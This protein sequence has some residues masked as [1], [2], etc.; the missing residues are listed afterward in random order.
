M[1]LETKPPKKR[2]IRVSPFQPPPLRDCA[3]VFGILILFLTWYSGIANRAAHI[4]LCFD[5]CKDLGPN[6][7]TCCG[8]EHP[9]IIDGNSVKLGTKY[10]NEEE[11]TKLKA[12]NTEI[13]LKE[14]TWEIFEKLD[15]QTRQC[16]FTQGTTY[17]EYMKNKGFKWTGQ[18]K[19]GQP[20]GTG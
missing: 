10:F 14:T 5:T 6:A 3:M 9:I 7:C 2:V 16:E 4:N 17:V 8:T 19:N 15:K 18:I 1:A 11:I 13:K 12:F 20:W